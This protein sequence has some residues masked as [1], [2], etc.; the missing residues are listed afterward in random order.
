[1]HKETSAEDNDR[2][3][4]QWDNV[5][6]AYISEILPGVH[7]VVSEQAYEQSVRDNTRYSDD[8]RVL[9]WIGRYL[10]SIFVETKHVTFIEKPAG[11]E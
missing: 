2:L 1:M 5:A 11:R 6:D 9:Y 10:S 7:L 3:N 4:I 8:D